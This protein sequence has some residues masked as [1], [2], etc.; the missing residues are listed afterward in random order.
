MDDAAD[1]IA[2][3][4][5]GTRSS[6]SQM[7]HRASKFV[8]NTGSPLYAGARLGGKGNDAKSHEVF[9]AV[10]F[11]PIGNS[12]TF[13]PPC[14]SFHPIA[15][16]VNTNHKHQPR[17]PNR[18]P[19][20]AAARQQGQQDKRPLAR[21]RRYGARRTRRSAGVCWCGRLP[22]QVTQF[23]QGCGWGACRRGT[24]SHLLPHK[25]KHTHTRPQIHCPLLG[26]S[27]LTGHRRVWA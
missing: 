20:P 7:Q 11:I 10:L 2:T 26:M 27:P 22:H 13:V 17:Q 14:T 15:S 4:R 25:Q 8:G 19:R 9:F 6:L 3:L 1:N 18:H 12:V 23:G 21:D 5:R 16:N 24:A